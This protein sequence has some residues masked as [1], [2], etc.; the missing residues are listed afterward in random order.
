MSSSSVTYTITPLGA[1][2]MDFADDQM[3]LKNLE[4]RKLLSGTSDGSP[5]ESGRS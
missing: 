5:D 4:H 3:G 2:L 1:A